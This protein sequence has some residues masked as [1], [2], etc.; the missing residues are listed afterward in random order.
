MLFDDFISTVVARIKDFLPDD[1]ADASVTCESVR[2]LGASYE[3]L[4][5]RKEGSSCAPAISLND[6]FDE[7][8]IIG[9]LTAVMT[10]I[11]LIITEADYDRYEGATSIF[12]DYSSAK[13][14]LFVRLSNAERNAATLDDCPHRIIED[15]VATYHILL[16]TDSDGYSSTLVTNILLSSFG[17]SADQL[18][19][20]AIRNSM[21]LLKPSFKSLGELLGL[22]PMGMGMFVLSNDAGLNGASVILYPNVLKTISEFLGGDFFILPSSIHEVIILAAAGKEACELAKIVKEVNG[23]AVS[24]PDQ[25]SDNVY[26]YN[27]ITDS[28]GL[29]EESSVSPISPLEQKRN[30]ILN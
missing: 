7:Y 1:F 10:N 27:S 29:T 19:E 16:R 12:N 13:S 20:D 24:V 18:H 14:K 4:I 25:L 5:V 15:L 3:G 17:I 28:W 8:C 26:F 9:D 21:T 2:K 11:A 22:P 23:S 30:V 6:A